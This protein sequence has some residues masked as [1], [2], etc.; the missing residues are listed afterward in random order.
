MINKSSSWAISYLKPP[1]DS[2]RPP[3]P[4]TPPDLLNICL[5]LPCDHVNRDGRVGL[6]YIN[7]ISS[8]T[9]LDTS[10]ILITTLIIIAQLGSP[11]RV[12]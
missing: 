6:C 10:C 4:P 3:A 9:I 12:A 2:L 7:P 8:M 1:R 5:R 11:A